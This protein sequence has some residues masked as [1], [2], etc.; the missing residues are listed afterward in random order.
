MFAFV[1]WDTKEK[2]LF[3]ARDRFGIKPFFYHISKEQFVWASEIKS[4]KALN[5]V[6]KNVDLFALDY[7]FAYGYTPREQTIYTEIKKLEPGCY[8]TLKATNLQPELRIKRYWKISYEP[9][10]TKSESYWKETLYHTLNESV[11]LH[12][13]SDVPLGAFLSGGIDSS[14]VVALMAKNSN[15][16]I[17]TFSIGFKEEEYSELKYARQVANLYAT[18]HHEFIVEPGSIDILPN[19]VRLYDEPFADSSAIP[20]Y[21]LSK[22]TRK[23]VTVALSGDGGDELFAGYSRY[24]KMLSI[25]GAFYNQKVA[26]RLLFGPINKTIPDY[27]WGKGYT[28]YLSKNKSQLAAYF[29]FWKDYER[30]K[31]FNREIQRNIEKNSAENYKKL[32]LDDAAGGVLSRMQQLDMKTYMVDDILTKVDRASMANSLEVRIPILDHK[33]AEI[34]FKIPSSLKLFENNKKHIFKEAFSSILPKEIITHKKQGFAVPLPLWFKGDL[35]EYAYCCL[36]GSNDLD[37][38]L[39]KKQVLQIVNNHQKGMRDYS[40]KIWSLLFLNEWIKQNK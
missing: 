38:Y 4:I 12:L 20:T 35:K 3:G 7:Y 27:V 37:T 17:S 28:Y 14:I 8:F 24:A 22:L 34:S 16:P 10:Y 11:K 15:G 6:N 5:L 21:Y 23:H 1:I 36:A 19:L 33:F 29:C 26:S 40:A 9:D 18:N 39:D 25:Y 32:I 2:T 13:I 31:I 30:R